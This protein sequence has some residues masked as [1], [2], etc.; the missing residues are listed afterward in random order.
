M[1]WMPVKGW[2][3][4]SARASAK[5]SARASARASASDPVWSFWSL[6]IYRYCCS[7]L[8]QGCGSTWSIWSSKSS[9]SMIGSDMPSAR[10]LLVSESVTSWNVAM[11][12]LLIVKIPQL[13]PSRHDSC[14]HSKV[15]SATTYWWR[16]FQKFQTHA[17]EK[18]L[19]CVGFCRHCQ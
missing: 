17:E 14:T 8:W 13:L 2:G 15:D 11:W 3:D 16:I 9:C 7:F 5:A 12:Y 10:S 6:L 18:C 4:A 1:S 19:M